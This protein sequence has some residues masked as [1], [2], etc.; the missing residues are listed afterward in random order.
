MRAG[1]GRWPRHDQQPYEFDLDRRLGPGLV[2]GGAG[3]RCATPPWSVPTPTS[4]A[5]RRTECDT[6][7]ECIGNTRS[8]A[9]DTDMGCPWPRTRSRSGPAPSGSRS[10]IRAPRPA[11]SPRK[12]TSVTSRTAAPRSTTPARWAEPWPLGAAN[13]RS[14]PTRP[15]ARDGL[16]PLSAAR[17]CPGRCG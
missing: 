7:A 10:G 2:P 11:P 5:S 15:P 1:R 16:H 14:A 17:R 4:S 9:R 13:W 3:H 8:A 12:P 6:D